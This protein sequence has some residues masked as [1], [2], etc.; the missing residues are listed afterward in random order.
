MGLFFQAQIIGPAY[1][2]INQSVACGTENPEHISLVA[3]QCSMRPSA[4]VVGFMSKIEYPSFTARFTCSWQ[5]GI[6]SIQAR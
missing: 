4:C 6:P 3:A 1:L 2:A 5:V